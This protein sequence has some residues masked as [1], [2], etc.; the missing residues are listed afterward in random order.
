[1]VHKED[2]ARPRGS[3]SRPHNHNREHE[4][5]SV[6]PAGT[7]IIARHTRHAPR[8]QDRRSQDATEEKAK[9]TSAPRH[10]QSEIEGPLREATKGS[11]PFLR[12]GLTKWPEVEVW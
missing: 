7:S 12:K 6:L 8:G 11:P 9:A 5:I 2:E 10:Y 4:R 1:M 3:L